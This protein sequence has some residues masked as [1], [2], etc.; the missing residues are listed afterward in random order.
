MQLK[1]GLIKTSGAVSADIRGVAMES[2]LAVDY[3][4]YPC[5]TTLEYL[6]VS[7]F[8]KFKINVSGVGFLSSPTSSIVTWLTKRWKSKIIE[9]IE[10]LVNKFIV[11]Q[12]K[13]FNCEKYRPNKT[14]QIP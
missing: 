14:F 11:S 13:K 2:K 8:G 7:K 6:R 1:Y 9:Q 3:G 10:T 12:L 4:Q 5:N